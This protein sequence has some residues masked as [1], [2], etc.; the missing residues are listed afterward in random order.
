[1]IVVRK[2]F[3]EILP[4][5]EELFF[6]QLNG[7]IESVDELCSLQITK[8]GKSYKFRISPSLPLYNNLII[9]ELTEFYNIFGIH[10][11]FSKS[12]KSSGTLY[13]SIDF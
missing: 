12:I 13:F 9:K 3:P 6:N 2:D 7:I 11:N 5:N 4:D 1:M 10:L 8:V